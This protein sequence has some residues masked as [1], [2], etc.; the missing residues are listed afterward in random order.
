MYS[1]LDS[2]DFCSSLL[3]S[4][5]DGIAVSV[6]VLNYELKVSV[7]GVGIWNSK[8]ITNFVFLCTKLV[9]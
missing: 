7:Y 1:I 2:V 6:Q 3:E 9:R 5:I 8:Y 4:K